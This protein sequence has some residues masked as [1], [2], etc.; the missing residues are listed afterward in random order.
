MTASRAAIEA[1]KDRREEVCAAIACDVLGGGALWRRHD[2]RGRAPSLY[3]F[4]I[5]FDDVHR[6]AL[7]VSAFTDEPAEAQRAALEGNDRRDSQVLTRTW[8]LGIPDRGL[9]LR[10]L[11]TGV[12][13]ER[14][15][16]ALAVLEANGHERFLAEDFWSITLRLG[17]SDP[18]AQAWRVLVELGIKD[19]SS[20][21]PR[22]GDTPYFELRRSVGLYVDPSSVN[23]AV[24]D[25]AA[26]NAAK[27]A[28]ATGVTAR[29]LFVPIYFGSPMEFM[30]SRHVEGTSSPAL[31]PDVTRAW[32]LGA[33]PEQVLYAE[34]PSDW[35]AVAFDPETT[36]DPRRWEA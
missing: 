22:A 18:V 23:R 4:T 31:P 16:G 30:A 32:V 14:V 8:S 25:R 2:V 17:S 3:D 6:E 7:E 9:D 27:L 1:E 33:P 36:N 29:H 15:E 26:S 24:E 35:T 10:G 34:P 20:L 12:L 5:E 13:H 28:A 21:P 19:G 11:R